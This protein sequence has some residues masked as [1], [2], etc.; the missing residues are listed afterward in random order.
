MKTEKINLG[1]NKT[2][3]IGSHLKISLATT[4]L[5]STPVDNHI[6]YSNLLKLFNIVWM[7]YHSS[8]AYESFE[9]DSNDIVPLWCYCYSCGVDFPVLIQLEGL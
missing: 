3:F 9:S 6:V 1:K 2:D 5:A 7:F 4:I 8:A